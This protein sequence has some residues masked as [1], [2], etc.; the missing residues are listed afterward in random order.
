MIQVFTYDVYSFLD[1]GSSLSFVT[2]YVAMNIDVFHEILLDLL[3][4][5][6]HVRESIQAK[7]VYHDCII[8]VDH[9]VPWL[10]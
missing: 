3:N 6:T 8:S 9:K 4:I 10:I 5:S 1:L 7:R 2:T